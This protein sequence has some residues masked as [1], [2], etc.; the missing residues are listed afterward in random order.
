MTGSVDPRDLRFASL[1]QPDELV[2]DLLTD[3]RL[4]GWTIDSRPTWTL[5]VPA[6]ATSRLQGWKIHVSATVVSAADVLAACAPILVTAQTQFKFASSLSDLAKLNELRASRGG[7]G[8]FLTAYPVDDQTFAELVKRLDEA[9]HGLAGPA[10]LSDQPY[11]PGSLVHFRYGEFDGVRA[12]GADGGYRRHLVAP[13]GHLVPDTRDAEFAPPPWAPPLP[14]DLHTGQAEVEPQPDSDEPTVVL[15]AD[16]YEVTAAVQHTN[17]GGVYL[18]LDRETDAEVILKEARPHVATDAQGRDVRDMLRHE[19]RLLRHLQPLG[20]TPRA[21]G[22]FIQE[23][24][25]FLVTEL[26]PGDSLRHGIGDGSG[27]RLH[28]VVD[29]VERLTRIVREIHRAGVVLRDLSPNNVMRLPDG[30]LRLIDLELAALQDN[31]EWLWLGA[32]GG[33]V[34]FSAPEQFRLSSPDPRADLFSLGAVVLYLVTGTNPDLAPD[35]PQLRTFEER[36]SALLEPPLAARSVPEPLR[37]IITGLTRT[38][39]AERI[40]LDTV[41]QLAAQARTIGDHDLR[42]PEGIETATPDT[43]WRQLVADIVGHLAAAASRQATIRPWPETGFGAEIEP[44]GVQHG[45]A[46]TIAVLSRMATHAEDE[47]AGELLR[48]LVDRVT[49]HL[50][51]DRH[52]LPGMHFGFAGTAWALCDASRALG[53]DDLAEI[54]IKLVN[55]MPVAWPS[56]DMTH[57]VAGLGTCL[58]HIWRHTGDTALLTRASACADHL[59]TVRLPG[60][61]AVWATDPSHDSELAGYRSY[62]F[63]HGTAGIGAFLLAVGQATGREE[64]LRVAVE[65]AD[66]L[67]RTAIWEDDAA[68]WPRTP[69]EDHGMPHWCNGSSGVGSFLCRLHAHSPDS[70]YHDVAVAAARAVMRSRWR[71]GT[72]YCHGLA[73]DGDYLLDLHQATGDHTYREWAGQLASL[74]WARRVYRDGRAVLP[75]ESGHDVTGGYGA[76]LSGQLS[77]LIRLR[78]GG[79]RLFHPPL[80]GQ[81]VTR[82]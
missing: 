65:C 14:L 51:H 2:R 56:P 69:D 61:E 36:V 32:G 58:L 55:G 80:H 72:C 16:R 77:F 76:G 8:K 12:L 38:D 3:I 44:C 17:R 63:A 26:L 71:S 81:E 28:T 6:V 5:V 59:L 67:I 22:E 13:D 79:P 27:L 50:A 11:R 41:E 21:L 62:G 40:T 53:R 20:V 1:R 66:T 15:L 52:R 43:Q 68:Y 46:G 23:G 24:H 74:L 49:R 37:R 10:I 25:Q 60:P 4:R 31:G 19:A 57:G 70:A 64:V 82:P 33:T 73:G 54:A 35:E 30:D 75:D 29:I 39:P 78:D 34:G 47:T 42:Q 9:T 18:A 45:V 7:S 48:T